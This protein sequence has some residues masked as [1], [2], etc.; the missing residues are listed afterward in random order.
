[1]EYHVENNIA[2]LTIHSFGQ[3][4][5]KNAKQNFRKFIDGAFAD[6]KTKNIQNLIVDLRDNTGGSDLN[7]EYFTSHF[8]DQP[9]RY[10]DRIEVTETVA[11]EIKGVSLR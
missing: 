10:W 3:T 9:F 6:L 7:A 5:I 11:K 1:M 2:I 4:D 8:F